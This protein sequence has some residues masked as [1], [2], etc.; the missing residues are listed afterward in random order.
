VKHLVL[1]TWP[2]VTI[3]AGTFAHRA[4]S[5]AAGRL[6][7]LCASGEIA[8][9]V[10]HVEA[11]RRFLEIPVCVSTTGCVVAECF[12]HLRRA[13]GDDFGDLVRW[14]A[15]FVSVEI[16]DPTWV[17]TLA[18]PVA[19]PFGATDAS[20]VAV[21]QSLP[22]AVLLLQDGRLHAWC[23]RQGVRVRT[24]FDVAGFRLTDT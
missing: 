4:T 6:T 16:R 12:H 8:F 23:L 3:L 14:A 15:T 20:V 7:R 2:L 22:G 1:D 13:A 18:H 24:C 10:Q 19:V 5:A 11:L 17:E 21:T 9:D